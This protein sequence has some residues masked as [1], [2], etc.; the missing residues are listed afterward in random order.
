M[1]QAGKS[2]RN[3]GFAF[4]HFENRDVAKKVMEEM[5]TKQF[6]GKI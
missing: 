5:N 6:H 3:K 4:L 2:T 1:T